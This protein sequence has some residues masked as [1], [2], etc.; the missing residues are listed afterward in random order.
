MGIARVNGIYRR[1][2]DIKAPHRYC[3]DILLGHKVQLSQLCAM[4]QLGD[5]PASS[6]LTFDR[7]TSL[8]QGVTVVGFALWDLVQMGRELGKT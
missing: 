1:L 8:Q 6:K 2:F 3:E 5:C 4:E 7:S